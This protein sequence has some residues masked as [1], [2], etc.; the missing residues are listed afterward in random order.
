MAD[1]ETYKTAS[2][3]Q[4][5]GSTEDFKKQKD[6]A[7]KRF[8]E[9][10]TT[11]NALMENMMGA[12]YYGARSKEFNS[13]TYGEL[14]QL[15][16]GFAKDNKNKLKK[17][18]KP[19]AG[20]KGNVKKMMNGGKVMGYKDGGSVSKPKRSAPEE[21]AAE[22]GMERQEKTF[23]NANKRDDD[24]YKKW[25]GRGTS[26]DEMAAK[27]YEDTMRKFKDEYAGAVEGTFRDI[28]NAKRYGRDAYKSRGF[29][30]GNSDTPKDK[31]SQKFMNG[32]VVKGYKDGGEVCRGGGAA[33]SGT[34]FRGVK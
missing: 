3:A 23:A 27:E 5:Y 6:A 15:L 12:G 28:K 1:K 30:Q 33:T 7:F 16:S 17:E 9:N 19:K 22:V 18:E 4:Q 31:G 14:E 24:T 34:K 26:G 32:G 20:P 25:E 21:K 2:G 8:L 11:K 10:P 13:D 29:G